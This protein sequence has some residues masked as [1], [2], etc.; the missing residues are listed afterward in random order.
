[1]SVLYENKGVRKLSNKQMFVFLKD[2]CTTIK[3]ESASKQLRKGRVS[4]DRAHFL[5]SKQILY[6]LCK[7]NKTL[8]YIKNDEYISAAANRANWIDTC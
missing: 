4:H 8:P 3:V 7:S 2:V 6:H 5:S 1:M